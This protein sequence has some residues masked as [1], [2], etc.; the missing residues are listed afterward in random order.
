[1]QQAL[2]AAQNPEYYNEM[3]KSNDRALR[4]IE[5]LPG[6]FS[7]LSRMYNQIENPMERAMD[8]MFRQRFGSNETK[9][10][11]VDT[12]QG[13]TH[14]PMENPWSNDFVQKRQQEKM[15]EQQKKLNQRLRKRNQMYNNDD[16]ILLNNNN[17]A[18]NASNNLLSDL[19]FVYCFSLFSLAILR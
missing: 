8:D 14:E 5:S 16:N 18:A 3:L 12:S 19:D 9:I 4:N 1:M 7:A 6:G 17:N 2:K 15:A 13:P 10:S 11:E